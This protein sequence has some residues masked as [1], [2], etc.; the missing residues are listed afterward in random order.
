MIKSSI[1][2]SEIRF[3]WNPFPYVFIIHVNSCVF[4]SH[5]NFYIWSMW[6]ETSH[7]NSREII[8]FMWQ[9]ARVNSCET[10]AHVKLHMCNNF[11]CEIHI[12]NDVQSFHVTS[13]TCGFMWTSSTCKGSHGLALL[14]ITS[15]EITSVKLCG[16]FVSDYNL[17]LITFK[18]NSIFSLMACTMVARQCIQNLNLEHV[19]L[20]AN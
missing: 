3:I 7:V 19:C 10:I 11:T 15:C 16:F 13:F 20:I 4:L 1:I 14:H 18:G 12:G 6:C 8:S 2:P 9:I 5:F 17:D